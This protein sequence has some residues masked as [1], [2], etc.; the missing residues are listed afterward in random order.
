MVTDVTRLST[1]VD[2]RSSRRRAAI[3]YG[4]WWLLKHI[5]VFRDLRVPS[6]YVVLLAFSIPILCGAALANLTERVGHWRIW[7]AAAIITIAAVDCIAFDWARLRE[8]PFPAKTLAGRSEPFYQ[9]QS[10]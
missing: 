4:P 8:I 10:S 9:V 7:I 1:L 2:R 5:P 3:P 6:R